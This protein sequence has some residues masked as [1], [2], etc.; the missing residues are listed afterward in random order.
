ML[1]E[2]QFLS[3]VQGPFYTAQIWTQKHD[4]GPAKYKLWSTMWSYMN[5][6][7]VCLKSFSLSQ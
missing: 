1:I 5:R 3:L 2:F 4:P 6:E 7:A